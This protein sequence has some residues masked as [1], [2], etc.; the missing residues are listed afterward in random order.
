[1]GFS[2][3]RGP[4]DD[5]ESLQ[6]LAKAVELGCTF[7]D[8]A[9]VYGYGHNEWIIGKFLKESKTPRDKLFIS[10]KCGFMVSRGFCSDSS[11]TDRFRKAGAHRRRHQYSTAHLGD[12]RRYHRAFRNYARPVLHSS[13]GL[14]YTF[15]REYRRFGKF[16]GEW[17][18]QV[19]WFIRG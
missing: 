18:M 1:M 4:A 5:K 19:Y 9:T 14:G 16:E 7:W 13:T 10:S 3:H 8:T 17:Q 12:Y 6:T 11:Y 2:H 15:G